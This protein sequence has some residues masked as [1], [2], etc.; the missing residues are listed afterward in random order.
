MGIILRVVFK[1][2]TQLFCMSIH[3]SDMQKETQDKKIIKPPNFLNVHRK[4]RECR[5]GGNN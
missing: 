1:F 3:Y 5:V 2:F 4:A